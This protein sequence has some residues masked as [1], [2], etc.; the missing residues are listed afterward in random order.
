MAFE[1]K[2]P[3]RLFGIHSD[4]LVYVCLQMMPMGW[5]SSVGIIQI[6]FKEFR[7][8]ILHGRAVVGGKGR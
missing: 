7:V 1:K 2:V 4:E 3:A 5:A 8:Q 6:L